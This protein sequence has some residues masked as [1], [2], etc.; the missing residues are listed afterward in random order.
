MLCFNQSIIKSM[1]KH[2]TKMYNNH[3]IKFNIMEVKYLSWKLK[4]NY[5]KI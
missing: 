5:L 3:A 1:V 2:V 4:K